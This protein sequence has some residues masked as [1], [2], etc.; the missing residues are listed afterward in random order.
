MMIIVS[1]ISINIYLLSYKLYNFAG[2]SDKKVWHDKSQIH[3]ASS[4]RS[5]TNKNSNSLRTENEIIFKLI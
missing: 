3:K 5:I 1:E 4:I 2:W